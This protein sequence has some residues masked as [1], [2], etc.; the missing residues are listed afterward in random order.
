M[1]QILPKPALGK[2]CNSCGY[3]CIEQPC[4]LA[5]EIMGDH[6]GPCKALEIDGD[7]R[8]CG[9]LRRPA[10]YMFGQEGVPESET[11]DVSVMFANALGIGLGCDAE[12]L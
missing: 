8:V 1:I 12:L 4:I 6:P 11:G 3:C 7:K 5:T 9:L 10:Y 2:P